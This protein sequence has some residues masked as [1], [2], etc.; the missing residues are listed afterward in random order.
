MNTITLEDGQLYM[1]INGQ[2]NK[3]EDCRC[4]DPAFKE[5]FLAFCRANL[6]AQRTEGGTPTIVFEGSIS[7]PRRRVRPRYTRPE[8]LPR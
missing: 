8:F 2:K 3:A 5:R 7:P 1:T 6:E 4:I